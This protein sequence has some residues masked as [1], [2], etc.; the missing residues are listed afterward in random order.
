MREGRRR[1]GS[2]TGTSVGLVALGAVAGLAL[3]LLVADRMGGIDGL[4]RRLRG[5]SDGR[6]ETFGDEELGRPDG[7]DEF[8]AHEFADAWDDHA[9]DYDDA[10][11]AAAYAPLPQ[12]RHAAVA[13]T[14]L[15]DPEELETRVLEVFRND[16]ELS[17]CA[18]D[19]SADE[20][21]V[22]ELAGWVSNASDIAHA[23]T[24]AR[25]VPDIGE[26]VSLLAVRPAAS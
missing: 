21:G 17:E 23:V 1:S 4:R 5:R 13:P 11:Y 2:S 10:E 14:G 15:L 16:P 24:L 12:R 6:T 25:G 7:L 22:I 26:V 8:S 3:G 18:I 9:D 19:I 20:D